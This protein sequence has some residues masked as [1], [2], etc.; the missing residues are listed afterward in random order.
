MISHILVE[1]GPF[2][3][4]KTI[5]TDMLTTLC[6]TILIDTKLVV[7]INSIAKTTSSLALG[8]ISR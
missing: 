8:I 5:I 1:Q 3:I 4:N 6:Q 7:L 2:T